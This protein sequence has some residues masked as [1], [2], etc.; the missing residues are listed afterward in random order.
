M[1]YAIRSHASRNEDAE[2][3]AQKEVLGCHRGG[4][5]FRAKARSSLSSN[6]NPRCAEPRVAKTRNRISVSCWASATVDSSSISLFTL[7]PRGLRQMLKPLMLTVRHSNCQNTHSLIS[8]M[9]SPGRTIPI[10]G[11]RSSARR[12]W[13]TLLVTIQSTLEATAN[14]IKWLSHSSARFGRQPYT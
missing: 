13:V 12:K 11:N 4:G 7:M 3:N 6:L 10:P 1:P 8:R 2:R 9:N 14:S 5:E